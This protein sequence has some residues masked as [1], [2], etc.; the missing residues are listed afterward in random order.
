MSALTDQS[1]SEIREKQFRWGNGL[2]IVKDAIHNR[3]GYWT[4]RVI[5]R[6]HKQHLWIDVLVEDDRII[7][8][9]PF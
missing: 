6:G 4:L 1:I 2:Y 7:F 8:V 9:D 5:R 3:N